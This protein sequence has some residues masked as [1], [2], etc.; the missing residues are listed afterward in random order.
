MTSRRGLGATKVRPGPAS[1]ERGAEFRGAWA[2]A[3]GNQSAN[4]GYKKYILLKLIGYPDLSLLTVLD[5]NIINQDLLDDVTC[6][7]RKRSDR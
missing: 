1:R 7:F 5:I 4:F 3:A 2:A 6:R